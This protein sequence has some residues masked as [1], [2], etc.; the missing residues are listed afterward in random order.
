MRL[1]RSHS[2][3]GYIDRYMYLRCTHL[4]ACLTDFPTLC[5]LVYWKKFKCAYS[6]KMG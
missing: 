4:I 6:T 3:R 2:G 5:I 1:V